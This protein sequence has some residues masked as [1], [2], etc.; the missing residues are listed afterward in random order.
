MEEFPG[1][2]TQGATMEKTKR[3]LI[4][5]VQLVLEANRQLNLNL[6]NERDV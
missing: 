5:A 3:N 6:I 2:N 1:V 4:Q